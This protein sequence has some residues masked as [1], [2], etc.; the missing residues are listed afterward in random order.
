MDHFPTIACPK[1]VT[2]DL[3]SKKNN[4]TSLETD[5]QNLDKKS[6]AGYIYVHIDFIC[7]VSI[8]EK[9][10]VAGADQPVS[11]GDKCAITPK[12][13]RHLDLPDVI[14]LFI[15]FVHP[16]ASEW[17]FNHHQG[18]A[19]SVPRLSAS[20]VQTFCKN[21]SDAESYSTLADELVDECSSPNT[22]EKSS[23]TTNHSRS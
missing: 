2:P 7:K 3:L 10:L 4:E 17:A 22:R 9:C 8:L 14:K 11:S 12:S 15:Q 19:L 18:H 20:F 5:T 23:S 16:P 21:C 13:K 1:C 6:H